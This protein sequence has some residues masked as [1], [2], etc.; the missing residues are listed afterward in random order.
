MYLLLLVETTEWRRA[1]IQGEADRE[2]ARAAEEDFVGED[3]DEGTSYREKK[4]DNSGD[5]ENGAP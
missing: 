4:T 2:V 3:V 5:L 1:D